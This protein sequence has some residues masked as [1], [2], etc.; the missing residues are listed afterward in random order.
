[1]EGLQILEYSDEHQVWFERLNRA[2]I[3][4]YFVMEP[5]DFDILQHPNNHI[6]SKGG[7]ILMAQ[8]GKE[9]AGTVALRYIVPGIFEFTK[10]AVDEK[11]QGKKVGLALALAAI[12][13]AKQL[14]G[15]TIFLYSNTKLEAAIHLYRK[16]GFQEIPVDGPYK[17][18]NIKMELKLSTL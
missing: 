4:R 18:V 6:I 16:L 5:L 8:L 12:E 14:S 11:Y 17:R 15:H 9:I 10:M 3:E 2:W 7:V 1:M 13:K